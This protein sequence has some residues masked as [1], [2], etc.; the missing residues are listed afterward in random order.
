[1]SDFPYSDKD[2]VVWTLA[3]S[4]TTDWLHDLKVQSS[5]DDHEEMLLAFMEWVTFLS[6]NKRNTINFSVSKY[7]CLPGNIEYEM[8]ITVCGICAGVLE[9]NEYSRLNNQV[10]I[11]QALQNEITSN[12]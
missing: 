3:N 5:T 12:T 4:N 8:T 2:L 6:N 1:M 9:L 11:N 10:L 7:V